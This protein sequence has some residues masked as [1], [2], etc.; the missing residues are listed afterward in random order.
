MLP[1]EVV[2][3]GYGLYVGDTYC[4]SGLILGTFFDRAS[5]TSSYMSWDSDDVI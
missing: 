4:A 1:Y 3:L 5:E 2:T